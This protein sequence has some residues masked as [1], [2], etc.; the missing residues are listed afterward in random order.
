MGDED[1]QFE[2]TQQKLDKARKEGQ[3]VKSKD[4]SMAI[5]MIVMFF[6]VFKLAPFIWDKITHLFVLLY[7]QIPNKHLED[8]GYTYIFFV[9]I[10]PTI[11]ILMPI[12]IL[13]AFMGILGDLVQIGPLFTVTPL[14]PKLDKLN[15]T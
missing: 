1:K 10:V 5:G 14:S 12:L 15:P 3:V 4:F 8:I 7:E 13:A 9:T 6:A 2:A 11:L